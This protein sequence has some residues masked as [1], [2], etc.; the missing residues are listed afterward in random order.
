MVATCCLF[1]YE[2]TWESAKKMILSDFKI[3]EKLVEFKVAGKDD[4]FLRFRKIYLVN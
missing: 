4:K 1:G 2:E 3:L